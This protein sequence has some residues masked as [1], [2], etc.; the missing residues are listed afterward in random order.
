VRLSS[1]TL[2]AHIVVAIHGELDTTTA[3]SLREPL[4]VALHRTTYPMIIDLSDV[5]SCEAAGLAPLIG[6]HR[7]GR[8]HG[9]ALSLAAPRPEMSRLLRTTGLHRA[10]SIYSTIAT[11]ERHTGMPHPPP[12]RRPDGTGTP[13]R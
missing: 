7:R 9:T 12:R 1:R 3:A 2:P 13:V 8:L 5:S 6:A 11:A 4:L 10:F